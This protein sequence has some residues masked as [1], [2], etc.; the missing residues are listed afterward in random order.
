M[1]L[2]VQEASPFG[3]VSTAIVS[4]KLKMCCGRFYKSSCNIMA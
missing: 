3:I 1:N 4:Y 2:L